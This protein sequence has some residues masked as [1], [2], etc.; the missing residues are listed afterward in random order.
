MTEALVHLDTVWTPGAKNQIVDA[1]FE[2]VNFPHWAF[3]WTKL[4]SGT[5]LH[6]SEAWGL[7]L[8]SWNSSASASWFLISRFVGWHFSH[9]KETAFRPRGDV[10]L[11]V[12]GVSWGN[13][14]WVRAGVSKTL[15]AGK[16]TSYKF[17][18]SEEGCLIVLFVLSEQPWMSLSV[19]MKLVTIFSAKKRNKLCSR[20]FWAVRQ[21]V[22]SEFLQAWPRKDP[23]PN[24]VALLAWWRY[25][26]VYTATLADLENPFPSQVSSGSRCFS[27]ATVSY[28]GKFWS[29]LLTT[30]MD[31]ERSDP[32][33]GR[34]SYC[35]INIYCRFVFRMSKRPAQLTRDQH[36]NF[37][38]QHKTR[39]IKCAVSHFVF[40][41]QWKK[42][43][44]RFLS[45]FLARLF[46]CLSL[47]THLC[48]SFRQTL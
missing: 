3:C 9:D 12:M 32:M 39:E 48:C 20:V 46:S 47:T 24:A 40:P 38:C 19:D 4:M 22:C 26:W 29:C 45:V 15:T 16:A 17:I 27:H 42:S 41:Q 1:K 44:E 2:S 6:A 31:P 35:L 21:A 36:H 25:V 7:K 37:S 23:Q 30:I 11:L 18:C 43:L 33:C 14:T 10:M 28:L 13:C 8:Y 5:R 34:G